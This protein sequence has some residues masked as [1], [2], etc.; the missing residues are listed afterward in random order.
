MSNGG[1][2]DPLGTPIEVEAGDVV[3]GP[4]GRRQRPPH[5]VPI[6]GRGIPPVTD[7]RT[8]GA[9]VRPGEDDTQ[10]IQR[11]IDVTL[12]GGLIYFPPGTYNVGTSPT[13]LEDG[14]ID[15]STSV[16][17]VR[18]R[19]CLSF[20]GHGG[21][22]IL[23]RRRGAPL[24]ANPEELPPQTLFI[25]FDDIPGLLRIEDSK[26]IMIRRLTFDANGLEGFGIFQS[27]SPVSAPPFDARR[28]VV[29][30]GSCSGVQI[31]DNMFIDSNPRAPVW[32]FSPPAASSV[33]EIQRAAI[34]LDASIAPL[35]E[36]L[37]DDVLIARNR[38]EHQGIAVRMASRVRIARN[39][40][41]RPRVHGLLLGSAD[42]MALYDVDVCDNT[43]IDPQVS[44]ILVRAGLDSGPSGGVARVRIRRNTIR[45]S[46][47]THD[48]PASDEVSPGPVVTQD[49]GYGIHVGLGKRASEE[50]GGFSAELR[51]V[52]V[53]IER[54]L[55]HF[56]YRDEETR[57]HDSEN[58]GILLNGPADEPDVMVRFHGTRV[59]GNVVVGSRGYGIVCWNQWGAVV[60]GNLVADGVGGIFLGGESLAS[61]VRANSIRARDTALRVRGSNGRN[62]VTRNAVVDVVEI[63]VSTSGLAE[64]DLV[65]EPLYVEP[66]F[67]SPL[68][69]E[70]EPLVAAPR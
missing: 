66:G 16:L 30:I 40:V 63:L 33:K 70:S 58:E 1:P 42:V 11:A 27:H 52:A 54:N 23:K 9:G 61:E 28:A 48:Y 15:D 53:S 34:S 67:S 31:V 32:A 68:H 55:V 44:G 2:D 45:K 59:V 64:S 14:T 62:V 5:D 3:F 18:G 38:I 65:D 37:S 25:P 22:S 51:F 4:P 17:Q 46:I 12:D 26:G 49:N 57:E 13:M 35:D 56:S 39:V 24:P 21:A 50:I 60:A 6:G 29:F 20:V 19:H 8:F 10:A 7:V 41:W 43:I 47:E 36:H 69:L